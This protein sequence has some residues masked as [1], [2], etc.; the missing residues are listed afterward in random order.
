LIAPWAP[1]RRVDGYLP[2]EDHGLVGDGS[3]AALIA[4]DGAV[5]WLCAPRFDSPPLLCSLL[6]TS[7]GG[8]FRIALEGQIGRLKLV[9]ESQDA[10]AIRHHRSRLKTRLVHGDDIRPTWLWGGAD[11]ARGAA[12]LGRCRRRQPGG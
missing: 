3:T 11:G 10:L 12:R 1:F 9:D 7:R 4:R 5:V 2:L 6:D 8:H